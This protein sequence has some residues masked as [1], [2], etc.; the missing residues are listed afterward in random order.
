MRKYNIFNLI[1]V[2]GLVSF[3]FYY[4]HDYKTVSLK[5]DN[6]NILLDDESVIN[7]VNLDDD[8]GLQL[9]KAHKFGRRGLGIF[10]LLHED[11][12]VEDA[13][14]VLKESDRPAFSFL[15][16]KYAFGDDPT[17]YYK[18]MSMFLED[19]IRPHVAIYTLCGACRPPRIRGMNLASFQRRMSIPRL[20]RAFL[21]NRR[22]R[23]AYR[24]WVDN[25]KETFVDPY[26][27]ATYTI[28]MELEDNDGSRWDVVGRKVKVLRQSFRGY[29]NVTLARNAVGALPY[30][31]GRL[32]REIHSTQLSSLRL[33]N[34]GDIISFD[35]AYFNFP[36]EDVRRN[37][38]FRRN[39]HQGRVPNFPEILQLV[40][41][42]RRQRIDVYVWR[43]E[44]QG[45]DTDVRLHPRRRTYRILG[46]NHL[47]RLMR[48]K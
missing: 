24:N 19:G 45:L 29:R 44:F 21:T 1:I 43:F 37:P 25:I 27:E 28:I 23:R 41:Q 18:L 7:Y 5:E 20:Q 26:P 34:R 22:V 4:V 31:Y 11:F 10:A 48:G 14:E 39:H 3:F 40:R 2:L 42:A 9:T 38:G 17:N 13:Y 16:G 12:P 8:S 36:G 46:K 47:K 6:I 30:G 32:R 15:Y 33:L 35:G